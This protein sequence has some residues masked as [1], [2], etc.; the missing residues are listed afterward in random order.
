VE[1]NTVSGA[2]TVL[3]SLK[4]AKGSDDIEPGILPMFRLLTMVAWLI[5]C[6]SLVSLLAP[7]QLPNYLAIFCWI[8]YS[9]L[10]AY[11]SWQWLCHMLGRWYLPI[12]LGMS[13]IAPVV[14]QILAAKLR[15]DRGVLAAE[16]LQPSPNSLYV[17]L[18]IP[19]L[20]GAMQY[21]YR[22]LLGI[23]IGTSGLSVFLAHLLT[24]SIGNTVTE[25]AITR[26][27][28]LTLAGAIIVRLSKVQRQQ[29]L[30]LV[31]KNMQLTHYATTLEQ[32]AI[33][34]ER[35]RMAR[36]LHDTLAHTLSA[37]SVQ[38]QALDVL[39]DR[40]AAARQL[41]Q[42]TQEIT[43]QGL[44]EAR[45]TLY[46]LRASPLQAMGLEL[47]L[48]QL[49]EQ[50]SDRASLQVKCAIATPL[51]DLP[52]EV[53]QQIYR[54]T[55][56]ALHNVIQHACATVVEV[57]LEQRARQLCL[58]ITDDGVGFDPAKL[59]VSGHYGLLGMQERA[60]LIGGELTIDS[61]P[62]QGT[63][64]QLDVSIGLKSARAEL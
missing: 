1:Q 32:L 56:E 25:Q 13:A 23:M 64:V 12:A 38:L 61:Q 57:V 37:L 42:Q 55:E 21:G 59:P 16:A 47:A 48:R 7:H 26:L 43:R 30:E 40:P 28:M 17:W 5:L 29:R 15:L 11:L 20:L 3:R 33:S 2:S 45:G 49:V 63:T 39:L 60:N 34:R 10:W 8:Q 52:I 41:L 4:K 22:V 19:L 35:D 54:I 44:K 58:Q 53:E 31:Q 6:P 62:Q 24:P 18:L 50:F 27:L 36:E 46:A 14:F 51:E 9:L